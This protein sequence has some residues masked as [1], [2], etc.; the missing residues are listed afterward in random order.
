[1]GEASE[2]KESRRRRRETNP[3]DS[4]VP[5]GALLPVGLPDPATPAR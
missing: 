2:K 3:Q 5:A 1:M 4:P